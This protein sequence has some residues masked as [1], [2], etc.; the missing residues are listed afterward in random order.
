MK[1]REERHKL[2]II[3]NVEMA[4]CRLFTEIQRPQHPGGGRCEGSEAYYEKM[5]SITNKTYKPFCVVD[6]S[7]HDIKIN[8][9]FAKL[10]KECMKDIF[11]E[12]EANY[13]LLLYISL[14]KA[15]MEIASYNEDVTDY[16]NYYYSHN[17][18]DLMSVLFKDDYKIDINMFDS[19]H[20]DWCC[21]IYLSKGIQSVM[22]KDMI[23]DYLTNE[24]ESIDYEVKFKIEAYHTESEKQSVDSIRSTFNFDFK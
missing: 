9:N 7:K 16:I 21:N 17:D 4:K 20:L 13:R 22:I 14:I 18:E 24:T 1:R 12:A 3:T 19:H 6:Y 23:H 5:D 10:Y 2:D 15:T 11:P 8:E